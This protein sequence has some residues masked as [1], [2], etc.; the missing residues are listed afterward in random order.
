MLYTPL[1]L[2]LQSEAAYSAVAEETMAL[3]SDVPPFIHEGDGWI[4]KFL[5]M[6]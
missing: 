1:F 2:G 4:C 3:L 5:S 6:E